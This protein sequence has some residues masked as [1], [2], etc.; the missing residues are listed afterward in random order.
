MSTPKKIMVAIDQSDYSLASVLYSHALAAAVNASL[1]LVHIFNQRDYHTIY[2]TLHPYDPVLCER[3]AAEK[4]EER[5][6]F[7]EE[8]TI[9]AGAQ[10][11]VTQKIVRL[12]IPYLELLTVIEEEKPD[13]L[14][15]CI[16]GRSNLGDTI[17]GSCAQKMYRRSPIPL[18]SLRP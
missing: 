11:T 1:M 5:R 2:A 3:V 9:Q 8:L 13:L 18:L 10:K 16:K 6:Q 14:V 12:G 7:L 17:A 4:M 15:M